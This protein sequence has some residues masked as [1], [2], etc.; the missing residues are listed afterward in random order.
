MSRSY[1]KTPRFPTTCAESEKD[2]KR[3]ANRK[4]RRSTNMKLA[5]IEDDDSIDELVFPELRE[6][7]EVWTFSKDGK[8]YHSIDVASIGILEE[9]DWRVKAMRK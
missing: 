4:L 7:S 5:Q 9:N 1:K 6:V 3:F 2:D 8:G